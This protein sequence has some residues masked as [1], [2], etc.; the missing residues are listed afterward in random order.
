MHL[1]LETVGDTDV[2]LNF[3][4]STYTTMSNADASKILAKMKEFNAGLTGDGVRLS[5]NQLD[6]I[7]N[8]LNG[9]VENLRDKI[10]FLWQT[11]KWPEGQNSILFIVSTIF[12]R[13][14]HIDH[15]Q[16]NN[17]RRSILFG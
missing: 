7:Q 15:F 2:T 8:L 9:N 5:E 10:N 4:Q 3:P 13:L 12:N 11:L 14:K 6:E 17:F 16:I 1:I